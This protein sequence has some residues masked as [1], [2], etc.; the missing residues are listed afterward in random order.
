MN[1]T[2]PAGPAVAQA[3]PHRAKVD[4]KQTHQIAEFKH[5]LPLTC[6]R[7]GH[8]DGFGYAGAMDFQLHRWHLQSGKKTTLTGNLSWVRCIDASPR[9]GM[10]A[11]ADWAGEVCLFPAGDAADSAD[12]V[13]AVRS[14]TAHAGS[15]RWVRFSPDGRWLATCGNDLLVK[16]WDVETG[17][18]IARMAGHERH[19]YAVAFHPVQPFL[20]SQDLMGHM[21]AWAI[22]AGE[23]QQS[24]QLK[25]MTGYDTKFAADMGGARDLSFSA[26]GKLLATGGVTNVKNAF[27]GIQDPLVQLVDPATGPQKT[28]Y[29]A[30]SNFQGI[31]WGIRF[32]PDGFL[33]GCGANRTGK[34]ALWFW[35]PG[36]SAAFHTVDLKSA[37]R[38]FDLTADA[39]HLIISHAD[40]FLRTWRMT[41]KA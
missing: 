3:P 20:F 11:A 18:E 1:N 13:Q 27:A 28:L 5:E 7:L 30:E 24:W 17:E 4:V 25:A 19:P 32:H 40:G 35:K 38:G 26:D 16:L 41:A 6:C 21:K 36:T 23:Q 14:F 10:I 9:D 2:K 15:T 33:V 34:G 22:P 29:K 39:R 31:C 12:E 8:A 37:A